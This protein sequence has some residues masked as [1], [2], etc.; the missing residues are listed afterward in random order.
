MDSNDDE[1]ADGDFRMGEWLMVGYD[2]EKRRATIVYSPMF[3]FLEVD[4]QLHLMQTWLDKLAA[5]YDRI[6]DQPGG[7][8]DGDDEA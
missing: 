4:K 5:E 1:E 7:R 2:N 8:S 3:S 6:V